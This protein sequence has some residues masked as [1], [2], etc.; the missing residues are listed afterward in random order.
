MITPENKASLVPS[1]YSRIGALRLYSS[2]KEQGINDI[3]GFTRENVSWVVWQKPETTGNHAVAFFEEG[4][5]IIVAFSGTEYWVEQSR[6][7]SSS[8]LAKR[9][10]ERA[11]AKAGSNA[12]PSENLLTSTE[13]GMTDPSVLNRIGQKRIF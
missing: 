2:L 8:V 5:K 7:K 9:K 1:D 10:L 6:I 3:Q 11:V 12:V 4:K 13:L